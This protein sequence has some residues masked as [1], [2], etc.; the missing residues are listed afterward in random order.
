M[1]WTL[2]AHRTAWVA[3]FL[4]TTPALTATW[5]VD[6]DLVDLPSADFTVIQDALNAAADGDEI[7]VYPGTYPENVRVVNK[8]IT[9]RSTDGPEQTAIEGGSSST[10][11][12]LLESGGTPGTIDGFA[13][14]GYEKAVWIWEGY[15]EP[16][17]SVLKNCVIEGNGLGILCSQTSARI[18]GCV[19]ADNAPLGGINC[20]D[21]AS[22]HIVGCTIRNNRGEDGPYPGGGVF[23]VVDFWDFGSDIHTRPTIESTTFCGNLPRQ[24]YGPWND[25]GDVCIAFTCHDADADGVIDECGQVGDGVHEVPGE[26]ASIDAAIA[27]AGAGDEVL[28]GPD[29]WTS[30]GDWVLNPGGKQITIRASHGPDETFLDGEQN[31]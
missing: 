27:A 8:N 18:E 6:D 2:R 12:L 29:I 19:I 26:Y 5:T 9:L 20:S 3:V 16:S 7:V 1:P 31:R 11:L 10:G 23:S 21:Y 24:V 14:R 13:I 17:G 25:A 4:F 22:P 28:V 15:L 30:E